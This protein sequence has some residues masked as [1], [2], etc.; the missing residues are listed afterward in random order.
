MRTLRQRGYVAAIFLLAVRA[1]CR[2]R[3]DNDDLGIQS[4]GLWMHNTFS[5]D[6]SRPKALV[7]TNVSGSTATYS[8]RGKLERTGSS[9]E[10]E[11]EQHNTTITGTGTRISVFGAFPVGARSASSTAARPKTSCPP[12]RS[13]RPHS[14]NDYNRRTHDA[15]ESEDPFGHGAT[16]STHDRLCG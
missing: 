6:D 15:A 8:F 5:N 13:Q 14:T 3:V 10:I 9:G 11:H 7:G 2:Q 12:T 1:R 4:R 16:P